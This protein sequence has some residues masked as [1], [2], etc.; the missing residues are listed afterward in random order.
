MSRLLCCCR[1]PNTD[2]DDETP[3]EHTIEV[4]RPPTPPSFSDIDNATLSTPVL[5]ARRLRRCSLSDGKTF[6]N[7]Y[8]ITSLLSK[9]N[10]DVRI[11]CARCQTNNQSVAIKV[12]NTSLFDRLKSKVQNQK[13]IQSEI[14]IMKKLSHPNIVPLIEAIDDPTNAK[15]YLVMEYFPK[16]PV[17]SD[18]Y[19]LIT[20]ITP[21]HV[22]SYFRD[23]LLGLQY[24]H[25][26]GIIHRDLKPSNLLV[27]Q[28]NRV[29]ISD[30]GCSRDLGQ[31]LDDT[32]KRST[33][34]SLQD[35]TSPAFASPEV[36]SG[37]EE[38]S[39]KA[40]DIWALGVTLYLM[41]FGKLPFHHPS[42]FRLFQ[43]I[44]TQDLDF[45][46]D[47]DPLLANLLE[48]MLAKDP[49]ERACIDEIKQHPWVTDEGECPLPDQ[50]FTKITINTVDLFNAVRPLHNENENV[51]K[52]ASHTLILVHSDSE[53]SRRS[54]FICRNVTAS[55]RLCDASR[56]FQSSGSSLLDVSIPF[57]LFPHED[58]ITE[59]D[60]PASDSHSIW[61]VLPDSEVKFID[62]DGYDFLCSTDGSAEGPTFSNF[63]VTDAEED[64]V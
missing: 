55:P 18:N 35:F 24:L 17:L 42:L 58:P 27:C 12:F 48:L 56:S 5:N 49:A 10:N 19:K 61:D 26:Q 13:L 38:W 14:A 59:V 52:S 8:Q 32:L 22:W 44:A 53:A 57:S 41:A 36:V 7:Q 39:G 50:N 51:P 29:K 45:P 23:A 6:I 28:D 11:Y 47:V 31:S 3:S 54:S 9:G 60:T 21:S 30:F 2:L 20:S 62:S 63:S 37:G 64:V 34:Y 15:M 25:Q 16:G 40:S 1:I 33:S 4:A 46:P 43:L